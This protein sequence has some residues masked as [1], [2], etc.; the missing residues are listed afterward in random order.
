MLRL[1]GRKD[2]NILTGSLTAPMVPR[3]GETRE[4]W[5]EPKKRRKRQ[6][7]QI[8]FQL[9]VV[10]VVNN[11]FL[12]DENRWGEGRCPCVVVVPVEKS[13]GHKLKLLVE[14]LGIEHLKLV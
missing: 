13:Y 2:V 9:R 5:F 11:V 4:I 14:F 10:D 8:K 3:M 7:H 12:S 6:R 1:P